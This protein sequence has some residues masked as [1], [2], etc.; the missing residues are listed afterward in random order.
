MKFETEIL[1]TATPRDLRWARICLASVRHAHPEL[2]VR[3]LPGAPLPSSF[4]REA[5]D[6]FAVGVFPVEPR[7]YGWGF[8]KLEPLFQDEPGRRFLVLDADTVLF[9]PVAHLFDDK[10]IPFL[11]DDEP[12]PDE[13]IRRLYYDWEQVRTTDPLARKPAFVFNSGQWFG[14]SGVLSRDD[15]APWIEWTFPRSLQHPELFMPGDQGILNYLLNQRHQLDALPVQRHK[16]MAW[17]GH[18]LANLSVENP[19]APIVHWAGFKAPRLENLPGFDLLKHFED[20]YYSRLPDGNRLKERR[21]RDA[22][23][24]FEYRRHRTKL[25]QLMQRLRAKVRLSSSRSA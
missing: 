14:T 4:L 24:S 1:I 2:P 15:F 3:L 13:E 5:A 19:G 11:V 16:L 6:H 9:G 10:A 18:G 20:I 12:Q 25:V 22:A 8:V 21:A 23:A 17:P 7:E